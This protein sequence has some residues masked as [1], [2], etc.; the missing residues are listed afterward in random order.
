MA[1]DVCLAVAA[2]ESA[3]ALTSATWLGRS[4]LTEQIRR[5]ALLARREYVT[6]EE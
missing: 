2:I 4:G 1:D 5:L 6:L 3:M